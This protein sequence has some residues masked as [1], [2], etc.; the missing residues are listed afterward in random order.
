MEPE[1]RLNKLY[2]MT[3]GNFELIKLTDEDQ[4]A[5]LKI[6]FIMIISDARVEEGHALK[7]LDM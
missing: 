7:D 5:T 1:L 6:N 3:M 4:A 2:R